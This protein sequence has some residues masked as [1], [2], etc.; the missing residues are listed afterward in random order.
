[1]HIASWVEL[2]TFDDIAERE[3]KHIQVIFQLKDLSA[4]WIETSEDN[5]DHEGNEYS[6]VQFLN[7]WMGLYPGGSFIWIER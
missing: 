6:F 2:A 3:I 5:E 4:E 1:M 7:T